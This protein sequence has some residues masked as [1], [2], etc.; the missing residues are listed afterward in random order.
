MSLAKFNPRNSLS[1]SSI[2]FLLLP[3]G[4]VNTNKFTSQILAI[5]YSYNAKTYVI[6]AIPNNISTCLRIYDIPIINKTK[7]MP[8]SVF[9]NLRILTI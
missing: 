8:S 6:K 5:G 3:L 9:N 4:F 7:L 1:I 2:K